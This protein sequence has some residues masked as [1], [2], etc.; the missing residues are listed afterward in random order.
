MLSFYQLL[1]LS[2]LIYFINKIDVAL[3]V[4]FFFACFNDIGIFIYVFTFNFHFFI[5]L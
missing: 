1:F 5:A 3:I 2:I 4:F